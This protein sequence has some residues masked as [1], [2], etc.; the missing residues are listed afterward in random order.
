MIKVII[1]Q[2]VIIIINVFLH[3]DI[4]PPKMK[5]KLTEL[6]GELDNPEIT[7]VNNHL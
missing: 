3:K 2:E 1:H 4:V 5:Q 6:K 7:D